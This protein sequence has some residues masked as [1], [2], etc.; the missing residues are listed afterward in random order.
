MNTRDGVAAGEQSGYARA[1]M[2]CGIAV[3]EGADPPELP[4]CP[5]ARFD[6]A[7]GFDC[8]RT[9][10]EALQTLVARCRSDSSTVVATAAL[11][12]LARLH[13]CEQ[14]H[15]GV[16]M[17]QQASAH[18]ADQ[19]GHFVDSCLV[20]TDP[21][22][23][24]R[25]WLLDLSQSVPS[26]A[27]DT[28]VSLFLGRNEAFEAHLQ[29][30]P[31][32]AGLHG[33]LA[34]AHALFDRAGAQRYVA[35]LQRTLMAMAND[36]AQPLDRIDL[37]DAAEHA[38]L[39]AWNATDVDYPAELCVHDLFEAQ[40]ER[41]PDAVALRFEDQSLSYAELNRQANRLAHHLIA[42]GV[43]PDVRVAIC[44]DR[45]L[46]MVIGLYAILKAG[47]AYVPLDPAYPRERL[48]YQLDDSAPL[49]LLAQRALQTLVVDATV[50]TF[51]LDDLAQLSTPEHNPRP[52]GLTAQNMV[53]VIYTSGSTGKPK[54]VMN[55][56]DG[57]VNRLLW[58]RQQFGLDS[59]DRVLQKT[60]FG[61]DVSVW[62][63]FLPLQT[64]SEL[65]MARPGGHQD[66]QYLAECIK[67]NAITAVHFVPSMLQVFLDQEDLSCCAGLRHVM[68]SG[69]ALPAGLQNR[70]LERLPDIALH[71]LYGPTEA[72]VEVSYWR[73]R[74]EAT[75]VPI[76][77]PIANTQLH[78]VDRHL[79]PVPVGVAG[80]LLIGG[81]QVARGYLNRPELTDE[82]FVAD[83][84]APGGRLYKTGDLARW[85]EDGT[86][87]YLGRNDFQ[88]KIRGFRIE[89]GEIEAHL[90]EHPQVR[91]AVVL[92]RE[93][94]A[95]DLRLVAYVTGTEGS[96]QPEALRAHLSARLPQHMVPAAYVA[97]AQW[98]FS[99]NG[100]LDR[101]ALP[102]PD[103]G[104]YALQ[105]YEAP[106]GP[107][108][109]ALAQIWS[110]MLGHESVGRHD[111][112]F[113]LGGHSLQAIELIG[114]MRRAGL[115]VDAQA[116]FS[117]PTLQALAALAGT[118][119]A[120]IEIPANAIEPGCERIEP[121]ML[122]LVALTQADIDR[123]AA[124]VPGGAANI[125]DIY[126]LAPLQEGFLFHYLLES[127]GDL[128]LTVTALVSDG[129]ERIERYAQALREVVARHDILR[130]S[131]FWDELPEPVQVVWR[132]APLRVD[133]IA[134]DPADGDVLTQLR[135]RFDPRRYR[136]DIRQAPLRWLVIAHDE[137]NDRWV[138]LELLHHLIED[139][140]AAELVQQEIAAI[141]DG[142]GSE[143]PV[144]VPFREFVARTRMGVSREAHQAYFR[145]LLGDVDEPTAPFGL[146]D[147][148][149]DGSRTREGHLE[150]DPQLSRRLRG[151]ARKASVT[152][153]TLA[154]LAWAMVL[155]RTCDRDDVVFGTVMSGRMHGGDADRA[156]GLFINTLPVRIRLDDADVREGVRRTHEALTALLRHEHA[157]L[158]LAQNCSA[159]RAPLPLFTSLLNYRHFGDASTIDAHADG[160]SASWAGMHPQGDYERSN[161]PFDVSINDRG[162]DALSLDAQIDARIENLG[163]TPERVCAMLGTALDSLAKALDEAPDT[164][165]HALEVLPP[166]ERLQVLEVW[167]RSD[168]E[169][170]APQCVQALF[171]ARMAR[172]PDA[173][174][175]VHAGVDEIGY[176]ELNRR[177]NRLAHRLIASGLKPDDR[178]AIYLDR[179]VA[180]VIAILATL[181]AGGAYVPLDP[182]YPSERLEYMLGDVGAHTVLTQPGLR[183]GLP[184]TVAQV[185][186]VRGD[187]TDGEGFEETNPD[188]AA[189]GLR[190]D[191]LAYVIYTSGSTGLPKGVMIEHRG[192]V[193]LMRALEEGYDLRE[194]DR[195]LQFAALSFDMS[196]EE[197]FGALC[198]GSTLVLR[199]DEWI[200]DATTFWR[201][202]AEQRV[203]VL[204]LPTAFWHQLA[205][206]RG[207]ERV[208]E[209]VR[210]I[211]IGGEK[212]NTEMVARWF[213]RD[214][215]RPRLINAYGPTEATV[216]ATMC[217]VDGDPATQASIGKPILHTRIYLLDRHM[218]PVPAGAVGELYIGG[219]QVAR[220][221]LNR[222]QLTEE[223]FLA[224]PF[225][226]DGRMYRTGDLGRWR[227]DGSI[228]YLGRN[229]FQV[230]IRGFRIELGEIEARLAQYPGVR[231]A[232][233]EVREAAGDKRLV[234]YVEA[235]P[236]IVVDGEALHAHLAQTLPAYMVPVAYVVL[237]RMP[238]TANGKLDRKA[239]PD[240][241]ADAYRTREYEAPQ[242]ELETIV[243]QAWAEL[244]RRERVGRHDSFFELGGHSLLAVTLLSRLRRALAV[245]IS[246]KD[247]FARPVLADLA[248]HLQ[249][250]TRSEQQPIAPAP[251]D[252]ALPL[253]YAQERLWFLGQLDGGS[254]AYHIPMVVRLSGRLDVAV[255][256]RTL[257]RIVARH[258][259]LRTTFEREGG[260]TVQRIAAPDLG[261]DLRIEDLSGADQAQVQQRLDRE[262]VPAFD[263]QRGPLVR[264]LLLRIG[265][266]QHALAIVMHHIVSDGWSMGV[267]TEEL[268]ALYAAYLAGGD[269]P[270]PPLPIQYADY[271]VWQRQWLQGEVL[272]RQSAYW[273]AALTGAPALLELPTDRPRPGQQ[274][275]AGAVEPIEF[276]APLTRAL[277]QLA[278]RHGATVYM[279]VLAGWMATLSWLTGQE[280]I[281]VGTAVANRMRTEVEG[282]IG[283][284][285][286]TQALRAR[287]GGSLAKFLQQVKERVL[288]AQ[289]HQDLPFERVV[290]II[291]PQRSLAHA[292]IFQTMLAWQNNDEGELVL[293]GVRVAAMD[294]AHA[295]AKFDLS[296]DL[297]ELDGRIVGH[298][299][300]ATAL[301]DRSTV[302][303]HAGYL[304]RMLEA[305]AADDT[306]ALAD[307]DLLGEDERRLLVTDWNLIGT[308]VPHADAG[309]QADVGA[310]I[311]ELFQAQAAR[312]PDAIA[313]TWEG[314]ELG[315]A[316]LNR[317]ANRLAHHLIALGVR[318]DNR[319]AICVE[320]GLEMVVAMLAV[321][322][323]GGAYVPLD[324]VYP[325]ERLAYMLADSA[326]VAVL[327]DAGARAALGAAAG[328]LRV[329]ELG[330]DDVLW[331]ECSEDNPDVAAL[332]LH[333]RHLAYIIYTSGST[334]A[335]KGVMVEHANVV[336]LFRRTAQWFD[337]GA[338]DVWTLFHS[339]AFDFSVW[340]IWGALLYG[341]RLVVVPYA[342]SRS[343]G[344]FYRLLCEQQVTVLNQTPS[345]FNQ[346]IAAQAASEQA[347]GK[348]A[349]CL[350]QVVFGGEAL[351][352]RSL[353]PWYQRNPADAPR[354][355]NMYG[356]TETTVH[357]TYHALQPED[358]QRYQGRSPIGARIPDLRTYI[359]DPQRRPAPIGATGELY[360]GGAGV[361]RGYLNRPELTGERFIADPFVV[362]ERLYR[363]GD[364]GRWR[365]D[366]T[367]EYLGRN[368][369]QVKIRGFRIEL[370]EIEA[371]LAQYPGMQEVAVLAREDRSGD[372]R[373]VAYFSATGD[374]DLDDLRRH[375]G[376]TLPAYMVP[377]AYVAMPRMPLTANGKLDRKALPAPD[378]SAY[379][380]REYEAPVGPVET[381]L[382]QI[383]AEIL[384]LD[385]VGR[386]DNFF[387]LG[388]HSLLLMTLIERMR[389]IGL[390]AEVRVLFAAPTLQALALEVGGE[391]LA[392]QVPPNLIPADCAR[393]EPSML[394]LVALAQTDIDRI[395]TLVPG[396]AAN[397]QDI[398]PLAPLQA[399]FLFHYLLENEGDVYLTW[400]LLAS[401]TRER[402]DRYAQALQQVVDRHD[403]LRTAVVWDGLPEPVQVVWRHARLQVE[404]LEL[405][406]ADG[407]IGH[408]LTARF[409]PNHYRI[410]I[411]QAPMWKLFVARDEPNDRW[412]MLEMI[413]H[414]ID[415]HTT[416][417][418]VNHE[419]HCILEGRAD[420]LR[421][422][423]P[424]RDFIARTRLDVDQQEQEAYFRELLGDVDEPSAPFGLIDVRGDGSDISEATWALDPALC[425]RLRACARAA[426]VSP[427]ALCHLAWGLVLARTI[428]RDDVVF[429][430]IMLGRMH[431]GGERGMGVYINTLPLR[432]RIEADSAREGVRRTHRLLTDL[433]RHEHAP[434]N[435]TQRCSAVRPPLPLFS[436]LL[437]YR[438]EVPADLDGGSDAPVQAWN[439]MHFL[440]DEERSNYPF[441][442]SINDRLDGGFDFNF[443]VSSSAIVPERICAMLATALDSLVRA[444]EEA[445]DTALHALD[446]L[447]PDERRQ[448]LGHCD[449]SVSAT[450]PAHCLHAP[451]EAHAARDPDAPALIQDGRSLSYG[452]L[453]R[454][455]NRLAHHLIALGLQRDE[456]VAIY[457]ERS[458]DALIG[459]LAVLKAGGAFVPLDPAYP[460]ERL[461]YMLADTAPRAV[462][463]LRALRDTLPPGLP[464]VLAL[465]EDD[466][467]SD[468]A[469]TDPDRE[470][471]GL[472]PQHLA[473][474]IYPSGSTGQPKGVMVEHRQVAA[475]LRG[476]EDCYRLGAGDRVLQFSSLSFDASIEECFGPLCAGAALVLRDD[477]W[478][479]D[480]ATFWRH[481]REHGITM[482]SLPTAFWH[483]LGGGGFGDIPEAVQW[484]V[485]GGEKANPELLARW[486]QGGGVRPQLINAYGP[487]ETT[488]DAIVQ[489]VTDDPDLQHAIGRPLRHVRAYILDAHGQPAPIGVTGELYL[490]G[491]QVARGY[492]GRPELTAER[493]IDSPFVAG[494]R[495]YKT[496]DLASWREG[497]CIDY[498]GRNDFQVKIRG[499]R[500][501]LGEIEAHLAA[502]DQVGEAV[503][504]AREERAGDLRLVAYITAAEAQ[505]PDIDA[506]RKHLAAA[507]PAYMVPAAYVLLERLPLTA[508]GKLD[509]KALPAPDAQD[510][511]ARGFE[512]PLG[513]LEIALARLWADTLK[514]ERVGRRDHF[515]ELG[516]HSLLAVT[517][518]SRMRG[519]LALEVSLKD[520]FAHPVLAELAAHLHGRARREQRAIAPASREAA[521]PLSHAQ[522]RLWFLS[523]LD[524]ASG[525][526]HMPM[527]LRLRGELDVQALRRALD[528]IVARHEVL[529]TTFQRIDGAT[530][531][532]I[533]PADVGWALELH[534]LR[535]AVADDSVQQRL[536]EE[537][538]RAF[539]LKCGPLVRGQ[540]LRT[541]HDEH[542]LAI[543]MHHIV[544]DGWSMGIFADELG[545]LY[546]A[547]A[548]GG[549]GPLVEGPLVEDPLPPLPIQYADYALWQHQWLSGDVLHTQSRYW[550][551]AL[552]GAPALLELPTDRPRPAQ[553]SF[554]GDAV[555][556]EFDAV[557]IAA[558]RKLAQRRGSTLFMTVLAAWAAVLSR[559]SGQDDIVVGTAVAN[560]TRPEIEPLIGFFV[561]T[562]AIRV[563]IGSGARSASSASA[564]ELL[565][566]VK[567]RVLEAQDYQDLPFEQVVEIVN[568]A[569]NLAHAPIFQ[570]MLAWQNIDGGELRIPGLEVSEVEAAYRI[571][572]FD[573][574]LDLSEVGD[575]V[576]GQLEYASA[577]FDRTS[578]ERHLAYLQR[579]LGAMAADE[580]RAVAGIELVDSDER[581]RLLALGDGGDER[582]DLLP[583]LRDL[584]SPV[585][586]QA[587]RTPDALAAIEP[588]RSVDYRELSE[589]AHGVA[590]RLRELGVRPRDRV[591]LFADRSIDSL[592]GMLGILAAGAA[593][594][595]IDPGYPDERI[596]YVLDDAGIAA[597]LIADERYAMQ[598]QRAAQARAVLAGRILAV[599]AAVPHADAP[600]ME[601][602]DGDTAYVIYTSGST[603]LP[604][605]V[606]VPHR[607]ALNLVRGFIAAHNFAGLRLLMIPPLVFDASVGDV[608]PAL[609]VGAALVLHPS[610]ADLDAR[611]LQRFCAEHRVGAI[612]A[613]AAL[614]R[615]WTDGLVA[616]HVEL[617]GAELVL[618]DLRLM[619]FG[620]ESV[621]MELVRR[622]SVLTDGRIALNNH[623][624]P[625]EASVCATMLTTY[626]GSE[627]YGA[628][629]DGAELPIGRPLPGVRVYL[630]DDSLA[631]VPG[632]VIG[633][634]C[635]GGLG[636]ADGYQGTPDKS[637]ARFL[638]DPFAAAADAR[639]YR[640]GDRAR[641]NA[642]GSLQFLGRNDFQVKIRGFRVELGEIEA[643]LAECPGCAEVAV[644]AREDRPGDMRLVAYVRAGGDSSI[645]IESLQAR[646]SASL[647]EYMV[648]AAYVVL[649]RMPLTVNGKIDRKALPA[650]QA[651]AYLARP[652]VAPVGA[653]ETA[654]AGVWSQVLK[655]DR[656]GRHDNF[657]E[658]GGHSLLAV[659]LIERM[660]ATGLEV[661]VRA[662]FAAPT[663]QALAAA[664]GGADAA[665]AA[666][667]DNLIPEGCES[668]VPQMLPLV[669]LAQADIDRI[670][671][672]VPGGMANVQDIY[673]L[674]PLQE[675]L[676]F[677]HALDQRG[678]VFLAPTLYAVREREDFDRYVDA[679]RTVIGRHDVLRTALVWEGLPEPVQVVW[680]RAPLVVEEIELDPAD[681]DIAAQ[682][683]E[684]F[685]PLRYRL[686]LSKAPAWRWF[687]AR[688][689]RNGRWV[690]LELMHHT[691]SDHTSLQMV[692]EEIAAILAGRSA[693]LLAPVPFRRFVAQTRRE[694]ERGEHE[695][696]FRDM[697][698]D[699][700]AP[701]AP[702]GLLDTHGDGERI[703][704][705]D[706]ELDDSL[707]RRLRAA[708]RAAGVAPATLCH[709]AWALLLARVC[710]RED[711]VF[712]TVMFGRMR[713]GEHADR[714]MGPFINTLP[715]RLRVDAT[716]VI[717]GVRL[718]HERLTGLLR[719]EHAPIGLA[720]RCSAV[721]VP[722]PLFTSLLN[723]R[724]QTTEAA[725]A[726]E[727]GSIGGL[728][729]LAGSERTN[730]PLTVSVDDSDDGR[731]GFNVQVDAAVDPQR[732]GAAFETAL[733]A[734]AQALEQ[735]PDTPLNRLDVLAANERERILTLG[736]GKRVDVPWIC[737][738]ELFQAQVA[739]TPDAPAVAHAG[740]ILS[741]VE[742]NRRANRLAHCLIALG[743]GPDAR[744]GLCLP[745][746]PDL[747]VAALAVLKAGGAY[748]ALDPDYP[749]ER[750]A[751]ILDDSAPQVVIGSA[752]TRSAL[753]GTMAAA[754]LTPD[755]TADAKEHDP[756]CAVLGLRPEHLAYLVYTSGSTGTPKGVMIEHRNAVNFLTWAA[757][758]FNADDLAHTLF[759]TSLNFDLSV[760]EC[761]APLSVGGCVELVADAL[762]LR[763]ETDARLLNTVPSAL[764]AWLDA[765]AIGAQVHTINVAGE[766]LTRELAERVFAQTSV[767]R[768]CNLYGPSETTTYSTWVA[769]DRDSGFA[770]HIGR[771]V[772]NTRIYVLDAQRRPLPQGAVGEIWIGGAGV[773]RGYFN[774]PALTAERFLDDP[775]VPGER[776]YRTGDLGRWR[777][778]GALEYLGRN[779]FQVKLRGF[780]I[781]LGE[782][783]S[784]LLAHADVRE[785]V[786]VV[787][788]DAPGDPR[789]VAYVVGEADAATLRA[790]LSAL[791]PQ[792]MVPSTVVRLERLPLAAN[793]K[794]D[795]KSL[796]APQAE[797]YAT[798][799]Y[800]APQGATEI[801]LARIW[802]Q[803]LGR[804]RIGRHDDF[805]AL[806][807]H[808][809]LAMRILSHA[810]R[811]GLALALADV[812]RQP[813]LAA[814]AAS[815]RELSAPVARATVVPIRPADASGG[816]AGPLFLCHDGHG[817]D[818]YMHVLAR[819]LPAGLPVYGLPA[820]DS[821]D[822][823]Q[824][825][826][827]AAAMLVAIRET[828]AH[829]PYR[830]GGWSF[831][832]VL[833]YEIARQLRLQGER[834][835]F[836]GLI[837]SHH[838]SAHRDD[839]QTDAAPV[840]A[841]GQSCGRALQAADASA[842]DG[843]AAH[844]ECSML[845]DGS[846]ASQSHALR[847]RLLGYQDALRRYHP[848]PIDTAVRLFVAEQRSDSLLPALGW[849]RCVPAVALRLQTVPGNHRSMM[850][851]P[852]I[853]VLAQALAAALTVQSSD[854][855]NETMAL[856]L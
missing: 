834:I 651:D 315:Y 787:R 168:A 417:E 45:S 809:L 425:A 426:E 789:L 405:D 32:E 777:N 158:N 466:L 631:L 205:D 795:R 666:V 803:V 83:P 842:S 237:K 2:D 98:P 561:N 368:D 235:E 845:A 633:E 404:T 607:G 566:Q 734:V 392:P 582:A 701:T 839:P 344:D 488:V 134:L 422:P 36:D 128:Y 352:L 824:V 197:C 433:L 8:D 429:G 801:A 229:D 198:A 294:V 254:E 378:A 554:A 41:T 153:A 345:A 327:T 640:T 797:A 736:M 623:Y 514:L 411:R 772:A 669:A 130:T 419:I 11:G 516:G 645:D 149:G 505:T 690:A 421:P 599:A 720:Q 309:T 199:D 337:F 299:E 756:D 267:L 765:N 289:D 251:R 372:K 739:R 589:R 286:N 730:Y 190:P 246:L 443:Q 400:T 612:D 38:Q 312:A 183:A 792:H 646:L 744:V 535:G 543:T 300:F 398:Y 146:I 172:R 714:A 359:L 445:P 727:P 343:P 44:A 48:A 813:S 99:S 70:F 496:G 591:A 779:D 81:V 844:L 629:A 35:Y 437:N 652:Y 597:L 825:P 244:L 643:R 77:R 694:T 766:P 124:A 711:V 526:Y 76:G 708:A 162:G 166:E 473:S 263:L 837:D 497:G 584:Y 829:G 336:R 347:A 131:F 442:L 699:V 450:A 194:D 773:A 331:R 559:L 805:F 661:D 397:I 371:R 472:R 746:D 682:L 206:D 133:E 379:L 463:T 272:E 138:A 702:F 203:S 34:Y 186:E 245:E 218:Q 780:R 351:E 55:Q 15:V 481:C 51:W 92:A 74:P 752:D 507:L 686:D 364:L 247:L 187:E 163:T 227:V 255:L 637:A 533:A 282:I 448:V 578:V 432:I 212:V 275:F 5:D 621:P 30:T 770:P 830:I 848:Q 241:G 29:L 794:L 634:L 508:N 61:F 129:R 823:Q 700:D 47:G 123:I 328:T 618:P 268:S 636:V 616:L 24:V 52:A 531:Q 832:G 835:G 610:P 546:A 506:L 763:P 653:A 828:Q 811:H 688:D 116:L 126:P 46:E 705:A 384:K 726:D 389:Q 764:R 515:F 656:V 170:P 716:P 164:A 180:M 530:V 460:R 748:L 391:S 536:D 851:S 670:V 569:R 317:R 14:L 598:A 277:K 846:S 261:F 605:G 141:L 137:P 179:S 94:Q 724:Y 354:L 791:L 453:N 358:L 833:A 167:N 383:W 220:G 375:L 253:S 204:N 796:P 719:H 580:H 486:F 691:T 230:K 571:A 25:Q 603:G 742:L 658:L 334:G 552:A 680:R 754:W 395:A 117:E 184:A 140:T 21:S 276:D 853:E 127:E 182:A 689:E 628:D 529:R 54:G 576:V 665:D 333:A 189:L 249:S 361:A 326:P 387:A 304:Q 741:Y 306:V 788:E 113:A 674:A 176:G 373:L 316:E 627:V 602:G 239:L 424:F 360:V 222:P 152:V 749:R 852:Q 693:E 96:P 114:H 49:L 211:M 160:T 553:Q 200:A 790:H 525:A 440:R 767:Q 683:R 407:D 107:A 815:A 713:A 657:F 105:A 53:Y 423:Q 695:A 85:H 509:R 154:H 95:G 557:L 231:E 188:P 725:G 511:S 590:W 84:F 759:S 143:L 655:L 751:W 248:A 120:A 16:P 673:P 471:L 283:F 319:V 385:R 290:E 520:L 332:G 827:I 609:S 363:T 502:H 806:G 650:P 341:G 649:E 762:A 259:V 308:D 778:D 697:L 681:G 847:R 820:L 413:H 350:R 250:Q 781:E 428:G 324:P 435:V 577:L 39:A 558:L 775:F 406:P 401:E 504:V 608:F 625:T 161:Y 390:K 210:Q 493:F 573:L 733:A 329:F 735:A 710:G 715:L 111:N 144:P 278:Q 818:L 78:V 367:I 13:G 723:Y 418:F 382:A 335:P 213:Q 761:F 416:I 338:G 782:I 807:G 147:A 296:L 9:M 310:C 457:M 17:T 252:V 743:V 574:G 601:T 434:L 240:P 470:A 675:S 62:E 214:G 855:S 75:W 750:L 380:T 192:L 563:Q 340:E 836:L 490:G 236:D 169:P 64:G 102:A 399:G 604:K 151:V 100:K 40:V 849:E 512:A 173:V 20:A 59:C 594:V 104:A 524:G 755:D 280:D 768:L 812:F 215:H 454:R 193:T 687:I 527:A 528:R 256:R 342:T 570:V 301:F 600:A 108:E 709:L 614:W 541:A 346:L 349:H 477:E 539:D 662:L 305:M 663:L 707:G 648:P 464:A 177:A 357:V 223:R 191:H 221:Y 159:V 121:Q 548:A 499:F 402:I 592:I 850:Q 427:A 228:E 56:H 672:G 311:H 165:L 817:D 685:D 303:R 639:L 271:A 738:H 86:I 234:G 376:E 668:I 101:K 66:R 97:M 698:G 467:A 821:P 630:L 110:Q 760:F 297:A 718:T 365:S 613:P 816:E 65:V 783:E 551:R 581:A 420:A 491:A 615:R 522:Q 63:L 274:S 106:Q 19:R 288:E 729:M 620:G 550:Q 224:D 572:K 458:F 67:A 139:R 476:L 72:A 320:R 587:R 444:L 500:I 284:F 537:A 679:V 26:L 145:G 545:A 583:G 704:E 82:R 810:H 712:G 774:R 632:G 89:L 156:M 521:L 814:L 737:L 593:Y 122:P 475:L 560:R 314:R 798:Q 410:D 226:T 518:L 348:N 776:M 298:L 265:E 325:P 28:P 295:T 840:E 549:E 495:L 238:L 538:A 856:P 302:Q 660:R 841:L 262:V 257:D 386:N 642:D 202:C 258:E 430:T 771:P 185:I 483:Q 157:P 225:A 804:E 438:H 112:F 822:S 611:E 556:V 260:R 370:G 242:G 178:V 366:G 415:D 769:M 279:T 125:Q 489:T 356:I 800:E 439:G 313:L 323:A 568:P 396:G 69:E 456:R 90:C 217:V 388:G 484:V 201:R 355:V 501:E 626:D 586:A 175:V 619:M 452:E 57:V 562:Q 60:P 79:R 135:E 786:V 307:V 596:A 641:W 838:P 732:I 118:G 793:G 588:G 115:Q 676:L 155:A 826:V 753:P 43:G 318:P 7:F 692:Q 322:K 478:V 10:A 142:H 654:L 330:A 209:S 374:V 103:I 73:C 449:D 728:R 487:T 722:Q 617:H 717:E 37:L 353:A 233:V 6:D 136:A 677:H 27:G 451:F 785:A 369:F 403:I 50:P 58:G 88:V 216:D 585:L 270:L 232:V 12:T 68:C 377:A 579:M 414:L 799:A 455:A 196:V 745:R 831:G 647:P 71:N 409:H 678:D 758:A 339:F 293:P 174:A 119:T 503:V 22:K 80:E 740:R 243:A 87:E 264:G 854:R 480:A 684:R 292:P 462:L 638:A 819:H 547:Y 498:L 148:F 33:H 540:L 436:A 784:Q 393:I 534:D 208:P 150:L 843:L 532:C 564:A 494:D 459:M 285:V 555:P 4:F 362:G 431:A 606:I 181:K 441:D 492:L 1:Q 706:F 622:F 42:L 321:L 565:A 575:R 266:D 510:Y 635:I 523:Q 394:P 171:E 281:V 469:D 447:P 624:G 544:S 381:A 269:D 519:A 485:I 109:I 412:V 542:V 513:E 731:L 195:L 18:V 446:V 468:C 3:E 482:L 696:F 703:V 671:A 747:I 408:Q 474:V 595:P 219:A 667:P 479:A 465:D 31:G 721:P 757:D 291:N 287:A 91:E 802:E 664:V 273:R 567:A 517:L 808:S 207:G 461:H 644:L 132:E 93:E 659:S 23:T